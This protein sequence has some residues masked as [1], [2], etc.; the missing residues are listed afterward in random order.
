M[1]ERFVVPILL[2][3]GL[4]LY[5]PV[6]QAGLF[7]ID[8]GNV[9]AQARSLSDRSFQELFIR[10]GG[11]TY[12][13]PVLMLSYLIDISFWGENPGF[14][15]LFNILLHIVNACLVYL[16]VSLFYPLKKD[17]IRTM[18]L[19]AAIL[20]LVHPVNTESI[21]WISGRTD[22]LAACFTLSA[23]YLVLLSTQDLKRSR[24]WIAALLL[25]LGSLCKEVAF[26]TFPA[27]ALFLLLYRVKRPFLTPGSGLSWRLTAIAPMLLGGTSYLIMRTASFQ[28]VDK[29]IATVTNT[30][31]YQQPFS[32]AQQLI[33]DFGFYC[34]K[35][36]IPQ[37]LSLA[38]DQVHANYLWLGIV[39]IIL[40]LGLMITR[41][42]LM[43]MALL[44]A[45]TIFP[46]LLNALLHIAWTPYAERYL[47]LPA[48]VLSIALAL[49][50]TANKD[51]TQKYQ[52]VLLII[53]ICFFLPTTISRNWLWAKPLELTRLTH[54][55]N[56]GNPT[57]WSQYAIMLANQEFYDQSRSEFK[58][59]LKQHP[60]HLF[61]Y[62]SLASM[63]MYINEP[64]AARAVLERFFNK[65]LK[66]DS[67]IL[68]IML[69]INQQRLQAEQPADKYPK[70]RNELMD[71][72]RL[73]YNADRQTEHL[74]VIAELALNNNDYETTRAYLKKLIQNKHRP[75]ESDNRVSAL[76][77]ELRRKE[78]LP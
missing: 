35:L 44:I 30:K 13:R 20:F 8:D 16:N 29:G 60:E 1:R 21:N 38:I 75:T 5:F 14:M 33:T 4:A 31:T 76:N 19:V 3:L 23:T 47:Y 18:P 63:E 45:L 46:A 67:M 25:F 73:L 39:A 26:F 52:K 68:Q 41:N 17:V 9:L 69:E 34:K 66:A 54:Q 24:L 22:P 28:H 27:M 6:T 71:T 58:Q 59:A 61:T 74:L 40:F 53:L 50:W 10:G 70:I 36:I 51:K 48:A 7:V 11:H 2:I 77:A 37:P 78:R 62:E 42:H 65:E 49:P 15:H 64:E 43:G 72:H 12:Y 32:V 55:Q 56:P 57:V